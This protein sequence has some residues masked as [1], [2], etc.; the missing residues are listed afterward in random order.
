MSVFSQAFLD[1]KISFGQ[2]WAMTRDLVWSQLTAHQRSTA[3]AAALREARIIEANEPSFWSPAALAANSQ[4][5]N[6]VL[7]AR[8]KLWKQLEVE[9]V[10]QTATPHPYEPQ[11]VVPQKRVVG[12]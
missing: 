6:A 12:Q 10:T 7:E 11:P 8:R 9:P 4:L 3:V 2:I 5:D 1:R